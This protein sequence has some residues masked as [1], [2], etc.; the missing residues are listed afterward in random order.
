MTRDSAT[1]ARERDDDGAFVRQTSA[2]RDR[3]T[4]DGSSGYPAVAGRY[5]L[6]VSLACPWAHRAI[7]VRR[8][9]GLT[10]AIPMT[11]V[12]PVRD[13]RGWRFAADEPD[14][15]NGFEFLAEAYAASD[16][17]FDA[18]VTVPVL[19]DTVTGRIVNNESAELIE[20]LDSEFHAV[21]TRPELDLRP[22]ALS[23]DIDELNAW[24][25]DAI[26]DGVY[27]SGFAAGQAAYEAAVIPLFEALD[28]LE[29]RLADRRFLFGGRQTL[30]DWRLFT[31]L[32]RFDAVYV[33]HFKCNL[34]RI[35]D[36][37]NLFGYLRDL[38]Q[39]PGVAETVDFDHIKRHYYVTHGD[40]NPTRVVPVGP[41][42]D[43][44][45]PHGRESL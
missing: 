37:P 4:A 38:Y 22:E 18:R 13:E 30:A 17:A 16:P 36:Y 35:R 32:V 1:V 19:W 41:A 21:A 6:Y 12:D 34:R 28:T 44:S 25:Y 14:P 9:K 27:K 11:V 42:Q 43:L 31:T 10:D 2:F 23:D 39:T 3:V 45:A 40:I 5:H 33:G 8:L 26:N 15:V 29:E 7:V 20:M 24:I